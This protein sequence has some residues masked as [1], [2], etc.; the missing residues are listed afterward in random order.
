MAR[1][2]KNTKGLTREKAGKRRR[3][4]KYGQTALKHSRMG[5]YSCWYALGSVVL[6]LLSLGI[7][8]R[9]HGNAAGF[10]GGFGIVAVI[11]A[12]LGVRAGVKGLREREK[13]YISC[14]LGIAANILLL[15]SL[16]II[17]TGGLG[18]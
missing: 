16:L 9:M 7:A 4:R 1:N 17:F 8:F 13:K 14:R 18:K 3:T 15:L 2:G 6:I 10:V 11:F 5:T 12:V